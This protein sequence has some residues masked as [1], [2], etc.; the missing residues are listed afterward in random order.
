MR[1]ILDAFL[2][3]DVRPF[4]AGLP[5]RRDAALGRDAVVELR[6]EREGML[7]DVLLLLHAHRTRILV[8]VAMEATAACTAASARRRTSD[9]GRVR[10][11]HVQRL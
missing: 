11:S 8:A 10:T 4:L 9:E 3:Q 7:E 6:E 1:T 2:E 5:P